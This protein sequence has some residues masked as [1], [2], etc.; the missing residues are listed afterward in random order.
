MTTGKSMSDMELED[1]EPEQK[2]RLFEIAT[3]GK[4]GD[5]YVGCTYP[6]TWCPFG[7]QFNNLSMP[8]SDICILYDRDVKHSGV[9][10][11]RPMEA[12]KAAI[13]KVNRHLE[14]IIAT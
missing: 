11:L 8:P 10:L 1:F 5:F 2:K 6:C 3:M 7:I 4:C 14:R 12:T 13:A 9:F